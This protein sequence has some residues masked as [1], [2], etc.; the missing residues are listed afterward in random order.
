MATCVGGKTASLRLAWRSSIAI[1]GARDCLPSMTVAAS[2]AALA[3]EDT[4]NA[5]STEGGGSWASVRAAAAA[6]S[7]ASV[8]IESA[9]S[10]RLVYANWPTQPQRLQTGPSGGRARLAEGSGSAEWQ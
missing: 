4:D 3:A 7:A 10:V 1:E 9:A 2:F 6:A 5:D 8:P